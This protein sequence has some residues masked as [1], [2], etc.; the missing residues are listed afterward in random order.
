MLLLITKQA[1]GISKL[2]D[3]EL[4][5]QGNGVALN[6]HDIAYT[7]DHRIQRNLTL[8]ITGISEMMFIAIFS[9][10]SFAATRSWTT[11]SSR[12]SRSGCGR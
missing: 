2:I 6:C 5:S 7:E 12:R 4:G 9:G 3:T 11:G 10:T 1:R 8:C